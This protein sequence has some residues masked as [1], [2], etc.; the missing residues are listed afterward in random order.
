MS[1]VT[2]DARWLDDVLALCQQVANF[3]GEDHVDDLGLEAR[4]LFYEAGR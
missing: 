2:V 3:F 4:R 1:T